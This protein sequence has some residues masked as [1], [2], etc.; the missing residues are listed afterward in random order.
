MLVVM[1]LFPAFHSALRN[2]GPVRLLPSAQYLRHHPRASPAM[3]NG[4]N[5][6]RL[7]VRHVGDQ[8][9]ANQHETERPRSEV[10]A[11]VTGVRK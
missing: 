4:N 1:D 3:H 11:P 7:F 5:P 8:V 9:F 10:R 2:E 6:Q